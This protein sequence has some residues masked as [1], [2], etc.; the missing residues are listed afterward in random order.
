MVDNIVVIAIRLALGA[1]ESAIDH[2]VDEDPGRGQGVLLVWLT[3]AAFITVEAAGAA[4]L[5]DAGRGDFH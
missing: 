5:S 4:F 3:V 2:V 1:K